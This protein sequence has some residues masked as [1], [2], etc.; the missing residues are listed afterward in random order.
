MAK[1][2]KKKNSYNWFYKSIL[3]DSNPE[4]RIELKSFVTDNNEE[5]CHELKDFRG[6]GSYNWSR[7]SAKNK[8]HRDHSGL[9]Q[10]D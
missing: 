6:V 10:L 1:N 3:Q 5:C 8:S 2:H 7:M 9:W 4:L